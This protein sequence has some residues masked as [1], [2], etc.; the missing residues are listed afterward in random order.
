MSG[1]VYVFECDG[2]PSLLKIGFTD[3]DP[4]VRARELETTGVPGRLTVAFGIGVED[5]RGLEARVHRAL[6]PVHSNKEWFKCSKSHAIA[7]ILHE[8]GDESFQ[9]WGDSAA[10]LDT[11]PFPPGHPLKAL[12]APQCLGADEGS[13]PVSDVTSSFAPVR[14]LEGE[15]THICRSCGRERQIPADRFFHCSY[16]GKTDQID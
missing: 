2:A 11:S 16:C 12:Y 14:P 5:A 13:K 10:Y 8:L 6:L 7:V 9:T 3:R 4:D 1:W 15:M